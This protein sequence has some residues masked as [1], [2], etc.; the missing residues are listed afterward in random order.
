[1]PVKDLFCLTLYQPD[2]DQGMIEVK[3]KPALMAGF[4][5][6]GAS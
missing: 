3:K 2:S 4:E 5:D 1:M 6:R